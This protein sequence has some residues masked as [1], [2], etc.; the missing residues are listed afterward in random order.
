MPDKTVVRGMVLKRNAHTINFVSRFALH[1]AIFHTYN[2]ILILLGFTQPLLQAGFKTPA[3][4]VSDIRYHGKC[5]SPVYFKSNRTSKKKS[6]EIFCERKNLPL[7]LSVTSRHLR[8][9]SHSPNRPAAVLSGVNVG[10][11]SSRNC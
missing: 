11:Q 4:S 10:S 5:V 2:P 7:P 3:C 9:T 6:S 8:P 1:S